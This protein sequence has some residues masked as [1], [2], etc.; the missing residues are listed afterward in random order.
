MNLINKIFGKKDTKYEKLDV[1]NYNPSVDDVKGFITKWNINFPIDRWWRRK[2][3]VAFN[4]PTHREVSFLDM[5]IEWEEDKL[6]DSVYGEQKNP[7][8]MNKGEYMIKKE[9]NRTEEEKQKEFK[10]QFR[11]LMQKSKQ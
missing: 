7:Y 5:R 11:E 8:E 6:F 1:T 4:S 10:D 2:H 9:D 3:D